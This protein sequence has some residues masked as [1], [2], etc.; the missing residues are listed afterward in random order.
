MLKN[1]EKFLW[2]SEDSNFLGF[3]EETVVK[4]LNEGKTGT[5]YLEVTIPIV[6]AADIM[7]I[8]EIVTMPYLLHPKSATYQVKIGETFKE[9][10]I[11]MLRK[12]TWY[13]VDEGI[14]ASQA[15]EYTTR[16]ADNKL[17]KIPEKIQ[18]CLSKIHRGDLL[19]VAKT[20]KSKKTNTSEQITEIESG[21]MAI[22]SIEGIEVIVGC[23]KPN[24]NKEIKT[25][26][27]FK[28]LTIINVPRPCTIQID[29][30][31]FLN[32]PKTIARIS[33]NKTIVRYKVQEFK[34]FNPLLV[35]KMS[36]QHEVQLRTLKGLLT[37]TLEIT[38]TM[39]EIRRNTTGTKELITEL[40]SKIEETM[41]IEPFD[42]DI[43]TDVGHMFGV[44][45]AT[46]VTTTIVMLCCVSF[47]F[48][49]LCCNPARRL[50]HNKTFTQYGVED[51]ENPW[52]NTSLNE[53]SS[54]INVEMT[55]VSTLASDS[56]GD[57][58]TQRGLLY[59]SHRIESDREIGTFRD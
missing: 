39:S 36:N 6:N 11:V 28:Y 45:V 4:I 59:E 20:C 15:K 30:L 57:L 50:K 2:E 33:I 56:V 27:N 17:T 32:K 26:F 31:I 21:K 37:D 38:K 41:A 19:D 44:S 58:E 24:L 35:Y 3:Y 9:K 23:Y 49:Q 8:L 14:Q 34:E 10:T 42:T 18:E 53:E 51:M 47:I 13:T 54:G 7:E 29:N 16:Y 1:G 46:L 12:N 5:P 25:A 55:D 40:K 48:R 22:F 43:W 52:E